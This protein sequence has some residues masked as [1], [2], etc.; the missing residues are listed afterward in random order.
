MAELFKIIPLG[1][2]ALL[3]VTNPLVTVPLLLSLSG[4]MS[5][6]ERHHASLWTSIY[7]FLIMMVAFYAGQWVMHTF[8]ISIPG[9]RIAGGMIVAYLGFGM[10]FPGQQSTT[11]PRTEINNS[12]ANIAFIP[13]AMPT[14]AGPGTIA[15]ILSGADTIH[16]NNL[17][18]LATLL[19][20]TL[21]F[22]ATSLILWI[23]LRS[24]DTVMHVLGKG[25]IEVI[26]RLMGFLLIAMGVQFIINGVLEIIRNFALN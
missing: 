21:I 19:A 17:S 23:C 7:V 6:T 9:L 5:A 20:P 16:N 11:S 10:L 3:P 4:N 12:P 1:V 18:P 26:S 8:G 14:T 13:L 2:M 22:F 15:M 24:S 25:G